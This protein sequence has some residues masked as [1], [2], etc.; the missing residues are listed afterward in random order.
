[1]NNQTQNLSD[2]QREILSIIVDFYTKTV[3]P[4][5]SKAVSENFS[6]D[7]SSATIRNEMGELEE[8]GLINHPHTSAGRIPTDLGYRYYVDSLLKEKAVQ[9][10]ET[11]L[12]A[13]EYR[14]KAK[15]IEELVD[16]TARVLSSMTEQAGW[17]LFPNFRELILKQIELIAYGRSHLLVMW[18]STSGFVQNKMVDMEEMIPAED[19]ARL[20]RF[21]N[22]ELV[23]KRFSEIPQFLAGH[24]ANVRDSAAVLYRTALQIAERALVE[25]EERKLTLDGSRFIL[26]QP[27]FQTSEKARLLS[28]VLETKDTLRAVIEEDLCAGEVR[29]RIGHEN[30]SQEIRDCTIVIAPYHF[31]NQML[32]TLGILGPTRMPYA[33]VISLVDHVARRLTDSIERLI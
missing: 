30:I 16:R 24:L 9:A 4:V 33:R 20:N 7:V 28:R 14:Q 13:W 27:E 5:G 12:I 26:R 3:Q 1:M 25:E 10:A 21:L 17:V 19:I 15:S 23:G 22:S 29:V 6:S 2:R 32:G 18:A 11:A 8:F 31:K